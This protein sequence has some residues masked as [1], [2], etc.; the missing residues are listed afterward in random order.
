MS[1]YTTEV[2]FI[3]E[4]KSGLSES[5]GCD[6]V[7][8]IIANSW[9]KIFT[10]QCT[11]FDETYRSVLCK[12]ILKHYYLREIGA[13]TVGVWKLWMNTR[14]E[15]IMPYY[16]QLYKSELLEFNPFYDV[17]LTREHN[18]TGEEVSKGTGTSTET[19]ADNKNTTSGSETSKTGSG[20]SE[21]T[22]SISDDI[23]STNTRNTTGSTTNG[24]ETTD[25]RTGNGSRNQTTLGT[26]SKTDKYSDT[27]QGSIS[28]LSANTYLTNARIIDDSTTGSLNESTSDSS[29]GTT[30]TSGSGSEQSTITDNGSSE[31]SGTIKDNG[32][33]TDTEN[34]TNNYKETVAGTGTRS[35]NT[36]S[37]GTVNSTEDYLETVSGKQGT[38]S[39]SSLLAKYRETFL[40]IDMQVI[41]EFSDLF[42]GLW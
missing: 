3:C 19:T 13:E 31:E 9:D 4:S 14:L 10:T 23:S 22:R 40:N 30:K 32:G 26:E 39:Y 7:D 1:K 16:N 11:F 24:N 2:R 6:N 8:E 28:N 36:T 25:T 5:K 35:G 12:K 20:T 15:E 21:N 33:T 17:D 27:P 37:D 42:F 34:T 18:R 29:N 41:G 38:E